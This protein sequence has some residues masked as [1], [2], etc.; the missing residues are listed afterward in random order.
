MNAYETTWFL[1]L[2]RFRGWIEPLRG[3]NFRIE[4][5][6]AAAFLAL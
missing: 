6:G 3:R 5:M 4:V 1:S 2:L